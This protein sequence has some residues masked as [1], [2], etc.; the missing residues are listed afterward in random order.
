MDAAAAGRE[1]TGLP[2]AAGTWPPVLLQPPTRSDAQDAVAFLLQCG[3]RQGPHRPRAAAAAG[4]TAAR[5]SPTACTLAGG[6]RPGLPNPGRTGQHQR[7]RPQWKTSALCAQSRC[8]TRR[9]LPAG[10][11]MP[12]PSAWPACGR[13]SKTRAA[14]TARW[15]LLPYRTPRGP[16]SGLFV[17]RSSAPQP[18]SEGCEAHEGRAPHRAGAGVSQARQRKASSH[19]PPSLLRLCASPRRPHLVP[20][21]LLLLCLQVPADSVFVTRFMGEYT[22]T[23]PPDEFAAL[24]VSAVRA[25]LQALRAAAGRCATASSRCSACA[26]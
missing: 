13:S 1:P 26:L 20:L 4:S 7:R 19:F 23:V 22:E 18:R 25:L 11:R 21:P 14:C 6:T 17:P 2:L 12:A 15:V 8:S 16:S 24:P 5:L 3:S 9:T 10:T